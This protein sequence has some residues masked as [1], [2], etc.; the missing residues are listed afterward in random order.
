[1]APRPPVRSVTGGWPDRQAAR[2]RREPRVRG[3]LNDADPTF[4]A[5]GSTSDR[6][7]PTPGYPPSSEPST[8]AAPNGTATRPHS[9][10]EQAAGPGGRTGDPWSAGVRVHL[11]AGRAGRAGASWSRFRAEGRRVVHAGGRRRRVHAAS[12]AHR[13]TVGSLLCPRAARL[14]SPVAGRASGPA[15]A[16]WLL[17]RGDAAQRRSVPSRPVAGRCLSR[18]AVLPDARSGLRDV[19][20]AGTTPIHQ[21]SVVGPGHTDLAARPDRKCREGQRSGCRAGELARRLARSARTAPLRRGVLAG[22]RRASNL[23]PGLLRPVRLLR[24]HPVRGHLPVGAGAARDAAAC[25]VLRR[26]D[27][28]W[29]AY[30]RPATR[31]AAARAGVRVRVPALPV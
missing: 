7:T 12:A 10:H 15:G 8:H 19:A 2:V 21:F 24:V 5:R 30:P 27:A 26:A 9:A 16:R 29:T 4:P 13:R 6:S 28:R 23:P 17:P 11:R 3:V 18:L 14:A 25:G 22:P 31:R 1:M 20:D